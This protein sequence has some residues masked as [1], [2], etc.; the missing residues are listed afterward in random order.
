MISRDQEPYSGLIEGEETGSLIRSL[1]VEVDLFGLP[2]ALDRLNQLLSAAPVDLNHLGEAIAGDPSL[3][4]ESLK[5]CNSSLFG[6]SHP[7]ASLSQ[8]V[9]IMDA[10]IVRNLL[11]TC[12]LIRYTGAHVMAR[13]NRLFWRHSLLVAQLSRRVCEWADFA[14]PERVFLAGLLHDAGALPFLTLF[15]RIGASGPD[16]IFCQVGDSIE[17]QRRRYGVDH[18]ELGLKMGTVLGFP[19][20]LVEAAA[21]HHE[22]GAALAGISPVCFVSAGEALARSVAGKHS[23]PTGL[24]IRNALAEYLPGLT[25]AVSIGLVEALESDLR[26]GASPFEAIGGDVWENEPASSGSFPKTEK[27]S[28]AS[29]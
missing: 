26:T 18:C 14:Q 11:F 2:P 3:V 19:A 7:V 6:L 15:S 16:G 8:A 5:L 21:R 25:R 9:I 1:R 10:E 17:A 4:A 24:L 23:A 12:W 28:N 29:G 20:G 22:R 27:T 13:E